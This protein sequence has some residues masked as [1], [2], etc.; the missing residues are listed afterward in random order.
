MCSMICFHVFSNN[1]LCFHILEDKEQSGSLIS[2][3]FKLICDKFLLPYWNNL[4]KFVDH[5]KIHRFI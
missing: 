1:L 3:W 5:K 4:E 2:P